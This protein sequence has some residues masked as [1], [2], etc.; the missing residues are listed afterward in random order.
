[1]ENT[2]LNFTEVL[3]LKLEDVSPNPY[4]PRKFFEA[5]HLE[6][7]AESIRQYGVLQPISVRKAG[8][9]YEL[10]A[11]ER[12]LRASKLA[13]LETIPAVIVDIE[14]KDS[15]ILALIENM[16]RQDLNFIEEAEGFQ[17]LISDYAFTQEELARKLGKNQST[18]ANKIRILRLPKPIQKIIIDNNLTERHARALL[19]LPDEKVQ[20]EVL[21]KI[22]TKQL[23]VKSTEDLIE[24]ILQKETREE[25]K[26]SNIKERRLIKDIRLFTNTI[27]QAVE[28]MN[29][30]GVET[31]YEVLKK[32]NG[33]EITILVE[34]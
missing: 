20:R 27:K 25:K 6:E 19:R 18:V 23:N 28:I 11:G 8:L 13:G 29:K 7:L 31:V 4:Q 10:V 26:T 22:I 9:R 15:A 30:S 24:G 1:M 34:C 16:Q 21:K 17:H 14:T 3:Q 5:A 32:D 33:Y 2:A 12:R